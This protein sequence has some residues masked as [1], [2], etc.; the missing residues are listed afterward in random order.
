MLY[1]STD[2]DQ[3]Q[4]SGTRLCYLRILKLEIMHPRVVNSSTSTISK[5][6]N[7][8]TNLAAGLVETATPSLIVNSPTTHGNEMTLFPSLPLELALEV[9]PQALPPSQII[10]IKRI[11]IGRATALESHA[12]P[13]ALKILC[14]LEEAWGHPL[15]QSTIEKSRQEILGGH[16]EPLAPI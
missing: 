9:W 16:A 11:N 10:T 2:H 1:P 12:S 8:T 3:H 15:A 5:M 4:T 13:D 6:A 7:T 14:N